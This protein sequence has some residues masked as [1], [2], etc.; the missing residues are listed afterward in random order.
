MTRIL[1]FC[2]LLFT[3]SALAEVETTTITSGLAKFPASISSP[4]D[5]NIEGETL[6]RVILSPDLRI[7]RG[8]MVLYGNLFWSRDRARN[9]FATKQKAALGAEL[10]FPLGNGARIGFGAKYEIDNRDISRI[11][12]R[13]L[14]GTIDYSVYRRHDYV[15]GIRVLNG[16]ANLRF[17]GGA[18][19]QSANNF[20]AQGRF[21]WAWEPRKGAVKLYPFLAVGFTDDSAGYSH[22]NKA[23][24]EAGLRVKA[25]LAPKTD[26]SLSLRYIV[27]K[28]FETGALY[29]APRISLG[30]FGLF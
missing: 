22:N 21:E 28:R 3:S 17:P 25:K 8:D 19:E 2:L 6:L 12:Y 16:W 26:L 1:F 13:T 4:N 30:W 9:S 7:G 11:T 18:D 23:H 20:V 24:A 29:S 15:N 10:R 14:I 27:E 5:G